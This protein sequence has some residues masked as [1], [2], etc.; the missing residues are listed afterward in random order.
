MY[1]NPKEALLM[2]QK[3]QE[4]SWQ[5]DKDTFSKNYFDTIKQICDN[6]AK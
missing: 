5:F 3:A 1:K 2:A 4:R 6:N